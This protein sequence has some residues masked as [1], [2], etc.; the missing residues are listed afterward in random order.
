MAL[1][2]IKVTSCG[3]IQQPTYPQLSMPVGL[4]SVHVLLSGY[5]W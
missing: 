1:K 3:T 5:A 4:F 2:S